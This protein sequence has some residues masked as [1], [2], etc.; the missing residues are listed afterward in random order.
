[1]NYEFCVADIDI[2][3]EEVQQQELDNFKWIGEEVTEVI[4]RSPASVVARRVH[5]SSIPVSINTSIKT[6]GELTQT[7]NARFD[8]RCPNQWGAL[9]DA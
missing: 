4:E 8:S 2:I 6:A 3:P 9:Q 1:L 5:K 7:G